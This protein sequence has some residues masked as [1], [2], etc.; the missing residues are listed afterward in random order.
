MRVRAV[1]FLGALSISAC[2]PLAQMAEQMGNPVVAPPPYVVSVDAQT[3]HDTLPV[4][5]MHA[6]T[7]LSTR[8]LSR[9]SDFGHVDIPRLLRG[10][11]AVQV[12]ST[13]SNMPICPDQKNCAEGLNEIAL[14]AIV[15]G[16]PPPTWFSDKHRVLNEAQRL[17]ELAARDA[18]LLILRTRQ[19]L[20]ALLTAGRGRVG[21]LLAIEGAQAVGDTPNGVDELFAADF[22]MLG[23]THFLDNRVAGSAHGVRQYGITAFGDQVLARARTHGMIIDLAHASEQ[24]ITDFLRRPDHGPFVVS[25]G[26]VQHV[27][28]TPRNLSDAE[29]TAI[30]AAGGLIGLGAWPETMCLDESRPQ[31]EYVERWADAIEYVVELSRSIDPNRPYAHVAVGS[32][33]DGWVRTAFDATG[34]PLLTEALLRRGLPPEA[35]AAIMGGN[36]C[37][38]LLR[39]LPG[40]GEPPDPR[41]CVNRLGSTP[42]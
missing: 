38:L 5:D 16:W 21:G 30:I 3:L 12:F 29:I 26:G 8:D 15:S 17:H 35:I 6:D 32:D 11:V 19:D 39:A 27:C 7:L 37:R 36:T 2:T 4:V 40:H 28:N 33:F 1:L 22:R 42:L 14:L 24:T 34:W 41:L 25:H 31:R 9:Q 20:A 23:L 18:R 13:P 10:G